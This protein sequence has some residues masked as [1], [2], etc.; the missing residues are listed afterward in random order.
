MRGRQGRPLAKGYL[1]GTRSNFANHVVPCWRNRDLASITRRDVI[2][3]LDAVA[4]GE[5][6]EG[7]KAAKTAKRPAGGPVAANRVLAA[8]RAMFG[9]ALRR[10]LVDVN[11]CT[12]VEQPGGETRRDRTLTSDEMRALWPLFDGYAYPFGVL[13][14]CCC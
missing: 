12:A 4:A 10:G 9:L 8:L 7:A 14:A 13:F 11:P 3:L 2:A 1:N 6:P 5:A